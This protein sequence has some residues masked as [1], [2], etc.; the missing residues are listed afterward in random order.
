MTSIDEVKY[1][2][3]FSLERSGRSEA[4]AIYSSIPQSYS[5]YFSGLAAAKEIQAAQIRRTGSVS[6]EDY[7][8]VFRD[9][10]FKERSFAKGSIRAFFWRS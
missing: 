9:G 4:A 1:L 2:K 10:A 8:V 5:S 6:S 3:A 7:P